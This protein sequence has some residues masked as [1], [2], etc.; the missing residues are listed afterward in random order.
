MTLRR[1]DPASQ[2]APA[3]SPPADLVASAEMTAW[4]RELGLPDYAALWKWSVTHIARLW[5]RVWDRYDVQ[6]DGDP[7]IVLAD[8]AMPGAR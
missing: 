6:A 3:W 5:R 7:S 8:A 4:L 1:A 2:P